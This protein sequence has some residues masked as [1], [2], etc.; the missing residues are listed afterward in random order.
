MFAMYTVAYLL[1]HELTQVHTSLIFERLI[2]FSLITA[3]ALYFAITLHY[4]ISL[5]NVVQ[6]ER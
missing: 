4:I 6:I 1:I 5:V 2:V 3:C